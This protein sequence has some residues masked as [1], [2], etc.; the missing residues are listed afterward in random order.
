VDTVVTVVTQWRD[1]VIY[2]TVPADTVVDSV[3]VIAPCD[4]LLKGVR[5]KTATDIATAEAW[6]QGGK[7]RVKLVINERQL[8]I[9]I[10]S[11]ATLKK[12]TVTIVKTQVVEKKVIPTFYKAM[13]FVTG[14]LF[15]LVLAIIFLALRR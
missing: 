6:V 11:A 8:A 4:T 14:F 10:D 13:L 1:T 15:L 5:V 12:E 7:L 2:V 3:A 9:K